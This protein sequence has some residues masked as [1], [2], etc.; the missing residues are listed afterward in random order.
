MGENLNDS[1]VPSTVSCDSLTTDE[2]EF[3]TKVSW[4]WE[5]LLQSLVGTIGFLSNSLAIPI[6]CSK[7]MNSIFNRLL[8]FLAVFDNLYIICSVLEGIRKHSAFSQWHEYAFGH[9]LYQFHNFVLCC[10]IYITLTLALER[11][12]AVWRPVEYHNRCKGANPWRR[13]A[14]YVIP[15]FIF[16]VIFNIPKFFEVEFVVKQDVDQ[17]TNQTIYQTLASPTDLRLNDTYVIFYVNA[18]RL[19]V[20]GIIPFVLLSILNY[21]IYWVIK[22][23]REMINRPAFESQNVRSSSAAQKKANETQQ[24]V[25]L[26]IIVLLFFI[27]HTP[28][29][30]LNV[31]EFLTLESLRI[32][33]KQDC[34]GVSLWAFIWASVSH[35]LMTL[36]SSVN[37]FIY[38]F[39]STTFRQTLFGYFKKCCCFVPKCMEEPK[40]SMIALDYMD[41]FEPEVNPV[42]NTS[43]ELTI[44]SQTE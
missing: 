5:G 11:Y 8:V 37:F 24:A 7:D 12:R 33:I 26:F 27:C 30:V 29:F 42:G 2:I 43:I 9:V 20:Q 31:H 34:N 4:W 25:V 19:L 39:M 44:H 28:R 22:R 3:Y 10:S 17:N 14:N 18:A 36:N 6:L 40:S 38:C 21:R 13:V 1:L 23:R 15:V 41:G 32:S 35:F 16:S